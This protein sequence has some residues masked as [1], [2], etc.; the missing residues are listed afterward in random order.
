MRRYFFHVHNGTGL[1]QDQ[2]GVE[3]ASLEAARQLALIGIRSLVGEELESGL[4]DLN[5]RLDICDHAG[6][7]LL[8]LPFN[9][10]VE[11]R[12]PHKE[13]E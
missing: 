2:E 11:L 8:S 12:V 13:E 3:L 6:S 1:T 7:V 10:A 5:G 9:D 4:V